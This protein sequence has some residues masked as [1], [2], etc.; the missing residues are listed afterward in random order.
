VIPK[1]TPSPR[2]F[3]GAM[4]GSCDGACRSWRPRSKG[5]SLRTAEVGDGARKTGFW[6]AGLRRKAGRPRLEDGPLSP[7]SKGAGL[8][9]RITQPPTDE[10]ARFAYSN[11]LGKACRYTTD[12][13]GK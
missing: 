6:G 8:M 4:A 13:P 7:G 9:S 2:M 10:T 11:L 12:G 3:D 1:A 5:I